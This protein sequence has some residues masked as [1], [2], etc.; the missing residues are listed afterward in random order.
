MPRKEYTTHYIYKVTNIITNR[1]YIGMHS[2]FDVNDGYFG[3]GKILWR[4]INKY[5]KENH[6]KEILEFLSSRKLLAERE[7]EIVNIELLKD[8]LCM[9]LVVGGCNAILFGS[10]NGNYGKKITTQHLKLLRLGYNKFVK[11]NK[12]KCYEM[13][14]NARKFSTAFK[15]KKHSGAT[16]QKQRT[17]KL[18]KYTGKDNTQ[19]NTCWI[20]SE[21]LN[22]DK[23]IKKEKLDDYILDGWKIGRKYNYK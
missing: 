6:K 20:Y 22:V 13:A 2:T 10:E 21:I 9:N 14:I 18:G 4:S 19:Y 17:V 23:K 16:K 8:K 15:D 3:S 7:K 5:G 11:N 12:V 1:Y